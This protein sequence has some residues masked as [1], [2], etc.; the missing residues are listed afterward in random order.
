MLDYVHFSV[1]IRCRKRGRDE[2]INEEVKI[3]LCM[4]DTMKRRIMNIGR[5][6]P[7]GI[8]EYLLW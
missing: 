7:K 3:S 8:E 4:S 6:F 2:S 5:R 1:K